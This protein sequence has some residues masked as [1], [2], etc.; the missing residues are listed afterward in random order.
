MSTKFKSNRHGYRGHIA[1]RPIAGNRTPQHVQNLVV[2]DYAARKGLTYLLSA[3]E[4]SMPDCHL[5]LDGVMN[6]LG[7]CE[8]V[9]IYSLFMLPQDREA[10][11]VIYDRL[12][13]AGAVMYAA[14]EDY[15]IASARDVERVEEI[16]R[17]SEV[18]H[19]APVGL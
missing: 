2:R 12:L 17:I 1:S 11:H 4:F 8:G 16:W 9:I 18:L 19:E 10:R 14:V 7:T 15:R 13:T 6:E 5:V 3:T